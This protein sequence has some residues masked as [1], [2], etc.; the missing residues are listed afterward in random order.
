MC[1][2]VFAYRYGEADHPGP[3]DYYD[4]HLGTA[5]VAGAPNKSMEIAQLPYGFWGCT[6]THLTESGM[7]SFRSTF[8]SLRAQQNRAGHVTFGA[9]VPPR[10]PTSTAGTWAGVMAVSDAPLRTL[11]TPTDRAA[12]LAGRLHFVSL[13]LGEI[14][15][16]G[17]VM[18]GASQ[19]PTYTDP[20][21]ITSDIQQI[22]TDQLLHGR[23]GPRF[24]LGDFNMDLFSTA[25]SQY[26]HECGWRE[27]Q[28]FLHERDGTPIK[29]TC[30]QKTVRDFLWCSPELLA[31]IHSG[32]IIEHAF[33]DHDPVYATLRIPAKA[34]RYVHWPMPKV[35][36]WESVNMNAW[37]SSC[38]TVEP[39]VWTGD[40]TQAF[41][42][43]SSKVEQS[44]NGHYGSPP[45]PL[46]TACTGRAAVLKPKVGLMQQPHLKPPR[47]G[48]AALQCSFTCRAVHQWYKQLRRLQ[49]WRFCALNGLDTPG[50]QLYFVQTWKSIVQSKGF[51]NGFIA[52]WTTRSIRLQ[53]AP[54]RL[55]NTPPASTLAEVIYQDF[56]AN[57]RA[58]E[59]WHIQKRAKILQQRR[60]ESMKELF[61]PLKAES[62]STLDLLYKVDKF[63]VMDADYV[64]KHVLLNPVPD[65][66]RGFFECQNLR[67]SL[68][69]T[70]L[71]SDEADST[72]FVIKTDW[73]P[74]IGD[75]ILQKIP[76]S[77]MT[78]IQDQ[79]HQL[80][81]PRW[82][83]D[84]HLP[85]EVW[86]RIYAFSNAYLPRMQMEC[87]L[88]SGQDL[89][90][91][92]NAGKGLRTRGPDGWSKS[93]F[94]A[95][96]AHFANDLAQ[97]YLTVEKGSPWPKQAVRGH[98]TCL[99]KCD[100]ATVASQYRPVVLYSLTYRLWSSMR[101]RSL[102]PLLTKMADFHAFG[103]LAG[104][105]S[106]QLAFQVQA[107]IE[108]AVN[109]AETF[110]G[111]TTD[112]EKCF[113]YLQRAPTFHMA[114]LLGIPS[115]IL[116]AWK[117]F[118]D[119]MTRCFLIQGHL[120]PD[121]LSTNGLPEGDSLSCIGLLVM[122]FSLHLYMRCFAPDIDTWSY[123]DNLQLT[124]STP[125]SV[126][127][128]FLVMTSWAEL[129][130]LTLD[131]AKTVYWS[132]DA[133]A[134]R[135]FNALGLKTV[136][137][138]KDLGVSMIYGSRHRNAPLRERIL[139]VD[140]YW[141]KLSLMK[142]A[143]WYKILAIRMALLPRALYGVSHTRMGHCWIARLRTKA[144][145]ALKWDRPGASPL[146]R[147]A[148]IAPV[149][150]DPGFFELVVTWREF[151]CNL[152]TSHSMRELWSSY[153]TQR[154][155][156]AT[157]GPF[158]KIGQFCE[159]LHWYLDERLQLHVHDHLCYN[160]LQY[161][162]E[163]LE[164]LLQYVWHQ[165]IASLVSV[166]KDFQGLRGMNHEV[167]FPSNRLPV[168]DKELLG[169]IHDG[170][171]HLRTFKAKFDI[172]VDEACPHCGTP[173]T[174]AHRALT[175]PAFHDVRAQHMDCVQQ[176]HQQSKALTHHAIASANP[177]CWDFWAA[178]LELPTDG[179]SWCSRPT[180]DEVQHIFT[181]GS[182]ARPTSK[183]C[184]LA[185]WS[186]VLANASRPILSGLL[187]GMQQTINRAELFGVIVAVQ[188]TSH[189]GV[190][191][192]L[193]SDSQYVVDGY[194][195]LLLHSA[196]PHEWE[197]GDL[198]A[199]LLEWMRRCASV[200]AI[201]KVR[202]HQ[203]LCSSMTQLDQWKTYYNQMADTNAKLS[204]SYPAS[205]AVQRSWEL[206]CK[207][208][209]FQTTLTRR[210]RSFLLALAKQGLSSDVPADAEDEG[211]AAVLDVFGCPNHGDWVEYFPVSPE[212][213]LGRSSF[214]M[215]Y[216]LTAPLALLRWLQQ[217]SDEAD[218]VL[219]VSLLEICV[220]FL[221]PDTRSLF[222]SIL[223]EALSGLY[224]VSVLQV[225]FWV[226]LWLLS[227]LRLLGC[228]ERLFLCWT[229]L[230]NGE[231]LQDR[232][233][234][235][236][237]FSLQSLFHGLVML[238]T[239]HML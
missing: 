201:H 185:G 172:T 37:H 9:P 90:R 104:R 42:K 210:F 217:L 229:S 21:Q 224:R 10:S 110:C 48:E 28:A 3:M 228:S 119:E 13:H 138:A 74:E 162:F 212:L 91:T 105:S 58:F 70:G 31:Y 38:D 25:S 215:L 77:S 198:W 124:G 7:Q 103:Y 15:L 220:G 145:R 96:P 16:T 80:W 168:N 226:A 20:L 173:D 56:H 117:S 232:A 218:F 34:H 49:S 167:S 24:I 166:R 158:A 113:N 153:T 148:C 170:T 192:E 92:L 135:I 143:D 46:P 230:L 203:I 175:C 65:H 82:Q 131:Q 123:V 216:G 208:H 182:C 147:L 23:G 44:L 176:W 29:P 154:S 122:T 134:R 207:E 196:V 114:A 57:F 144:M 112:I 233:V 111:V 89:Q 197:N 183:S 94:K 132:S 27:I 214:L 26:W 128:S 157:H 14:Q 69:P 17:A 53:G 221:Q 88:F 127:Q 205:M 177:H 209:D 136:E 161:P 152:K 1:S 52:W 184:A 50:S 150:T 22:I 99:Q 139:A 33:P 55:L 107:S 101:S 227:I 59:T 54:D 118:L 19:G 62:K 125:A 41:M 186:L 87:P 236:T 68:L 181:D 115:Q 43:W 146:I 12:H 76:C 98:V 67:L 106:S 171:F 95:L 4:F 79:L 130:G 219:E 231:A 93:D 75:Q 237:N 189:F 66:T 100:E 190:C 39:H 8:R 137:F 116:C 11:R 235:C 97:L 36:N 30:K 108:Q 141:A 102:I 163:H 84:P 121:H 194:E 178:L 61:K 165:H 223:A 155:A 72:W 225:N 169:C 238:P 85:A 6:E 222:W 109:S 51:A 126:Q 83:L 239:A 71:S 60:E 142:V 193:W 151:Y 156:R 211:S 174:L 2:P 188:W 35:I 191:S 32:G 40:L 140:P 129:F 5:N 195:D 64:N 204:I 179:F 149:T 187:P 202:A 47:P 180:A 78:E 234:K 200:P 159:L 206:L 133:A 45:G 213:A 73:C 81:L 199:V 160:L 18:Y 120:G 63:E 86:Q 164:I